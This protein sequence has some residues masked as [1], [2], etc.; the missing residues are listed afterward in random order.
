MFGKRGEVRVEDLAGLIGRDVEALREAVGLHAVREAVV[1]DLGEP[2]LELVDLVLG[3]VEHARR[4][5]GVHVGAALERV[6]E[7]RVVGEVREHA[8]LDLRVV[9]GEQA[10]AVVGDE[11]APQL[12]PARGAHRARSGGSATPTRSARWWWRAD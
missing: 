8:Q 12:A 11:R 10:A 2:A 1:D 3:H 5:G 7:A 9:G 6:D 4:G